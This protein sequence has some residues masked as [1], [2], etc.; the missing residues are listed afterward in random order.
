MSQEVFG[1][2]LEV[3]KSTVSR[4]EAGR[5]PDTE[6]L[7]RIADFGGVTV[8]WLLRGERGAPPAAT[9]RGAGHDL[10]KTEEK[11]AVRGPGG[12]AAL[13]QALLV[14]IIS[15]VEKWLARRGLTL[16]P[17][18]K[19]ELIGILYQD[20][21]ARGQTVDEAAMGKAILRLVA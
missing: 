17:D 16:K 18:K 19:G 13:D 4:Y 2:M 11:P 8:D 12:A 21:A 9:G 7:E 14:Q 3:T 10:A 6:T 1:N 20:F 15:G 5:V